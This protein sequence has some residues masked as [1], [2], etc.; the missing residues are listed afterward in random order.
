M[1]SEITMEE[2]PRGSTKDW[3]SAQYLK[4]LNQRTRPSHDLL[5]QVPLSSPTYIIDVGCGPGNSTDV[6]ATRFP[7]AKV[8]GMDSSPDMITTARE[9]Y[10]NIEFAVADINNYS[11]EDPVDLIF[12]N[13][14][15][16]WIKYD[17]RIPAI[18]HL[19]RSLKCGGTFAMQVPDN[20]MEESHVAMRT[21]AEKG[22]WAEEL[23]RLQPAQ[24][25]FQTV[26][27]LYNELKPLCSS[28]DLWHTIYQHP[29]QNHQEIVEWLKGTGL[30]PFVNPLSLDESEGF[31]TEYLKEIKTLYPVSSD[32]TVL[33]RFPRLFMV[34]VRA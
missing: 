34:A 29:L 23:R 6:L 26:Q 22:P 1:T 28:I 10:P 2:L 13:A 27:E 15:F 16:Q 9:H 5:S 21:V 20:Y 19:I 3:S 14:V 8:L 18:K 12:S 7:D 24:G 4:F 17:D 32:G 33:L 31:L 25:P 11:P 30:R